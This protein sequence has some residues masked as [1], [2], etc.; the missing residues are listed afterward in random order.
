MSFAGSAPGVFNINVQPKPTNYPQSI[1]RTE[2][3][4]LYIPAEVGAR[5]VPQ[6]IV[7]DTNPVPPTVEKVVLP[8]EKPRLS[9]DPK[10]YRTVEERLRFFIEQGY[11]FTNVDITESRDD[12]TTRGEFV[13]PVF[14]ITNEFGEYNPLR[15][16]YDTA[17]N[18]RYDN[19]MPLNKYRTR[20][21]ALVDDRTFN[22]D[23]NPD[24]WYQYAWY[25]VPSFVGVMTL[26][27]KPITSA[28][29]EES[30]SGAGLVITQ[31]ES[32]TKEIVVDIATD[33]I[34]V[35]GEVIQAAPA[36]SFAVGTGLALLV[37]I[38]VGYILS[39]IVSGRTAA[40]TGGVLF[41]VIMF[42]I[43][44]YGAASSVFGFLFAH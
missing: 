34:E 1:P 41:A 33:S 11:Y 42:S 18:P 9:L 4:P 36:F 7:I 44:T 40:I 38:L 13:Y 31:V 20:L 17:Y 3:D 16:V 24:A 15:A 32:S 12:V 26:P 43:L 39:Y 27:T 37:S 35:V 14:R 23:K 5:Y 25:S 30:L 29:F 28:E 22:I 10:Y 21:A 6:E 2:S 8:F 19:Y